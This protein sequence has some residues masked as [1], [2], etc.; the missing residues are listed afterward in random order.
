VTQE[1]AK[2]YLDHEQREFLLLV[3]QFA[4]RN[5]YFAQLYSFLHVL[6]VMIHFYG[7]DGFG[8]RFYIKVPKAVPC[9][10]RAVKSARCLY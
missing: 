5:V 4:N 10:R 7:Q 6:V 9:H 8:G 3:D 2:S 1:C